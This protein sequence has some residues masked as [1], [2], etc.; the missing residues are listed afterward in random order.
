MSEDRR[1]G[2]GP[3]CASA[4][5]ARRRHPARDDAGD[6]REDGDRPVE[7]KPKLDVLDFWSI[8]KP[9]CPVS[10]VCA[11]RSPRSSARMRCARATTARA[12]PRSRHRRSSGCRATERRRGAR[13]WPHRTRCRSSTTWCPTEAAILIPTRE[14]EQGRFNF[15][16]ATVARHLRRM[17]QLLYSDAIVGFLYGVR[18]DSP[19]HRLESPAVVRLRP[20]R[21]DRGSA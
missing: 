20:G 19:E 18:R 4:V 15:K 1:R 21:G 3:Q 10:T 13:A 9:N 16:C 11:R 6:D 12:T 17:T 8:I 5:R 14:G 7:M 2:P